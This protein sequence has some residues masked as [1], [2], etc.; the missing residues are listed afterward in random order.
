MKN[1]WVIVA[2][3]LASLI[4]GSMLS[5]WWALEATGGILSGIA[6]MGAGLL[7]GLAGLWGGMIGL[8]AGLFGALVGIIV[9]VGAAL[10][11]IPLA[12]FGV[13][14]SV[15]FSLL[16][17]MIPLLLVVGFAAWMVHIG[18]RGGRD[19]PAAIAPPPSLPPV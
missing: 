10:L 13:M 11:A 7:S 15:F 9:A 6:G 2:I 17:V 14:L 1:A 5:P 4:V 16:P 18:L 8:A 12:L 19:R 3:V